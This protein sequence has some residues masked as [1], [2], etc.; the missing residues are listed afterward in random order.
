MKLLIVEDEASIRLGLRD[1]FAYHGYQVLLA[2][3][4][5]QALELARSESP[6]IMILDVML[7]FKS[8][9]EVC[10]T[11]RSENNQIPIIMLTAKDTEEDI[12][13]GLSL[14]ADDY[15]TKPFSIREL[16]LRVKALLKRTQPA[17]IE[18]IVLSE[19]EVMPEGLEGV[20]SNGEKVLFTQ[21]EIDIL[22]Y[23]EQKGEIPSSREQ[24]LKDIWGY[25]HP[26]QV[27]TR[28]VD[29]HIA[30]IR[31]KIE[32]DAKNPTHLITIRGKGYRLEKL[33]K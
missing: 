31:K 7:P 29:I 22:I 23:L 28:T 32:V 5:Q 20:R 9:F 10:E 14:G 3:D 21:R 33:I 8:G 30:K 25:Q 12:L 11:L 27:E 16:V 24:L 6:Q 1:L 13:N 4:G 17:S 26:E 19:I 18:K 15:V 2:E